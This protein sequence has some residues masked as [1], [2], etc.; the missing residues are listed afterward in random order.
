MLSLRRVHPDCQI[1]TLAFD[2]SD[3]AYLVGSDGMRL[4]DPDHHCRVMSWLKVPDDWTFLL[5]RT[6]ENSH[7]NSLVPKLQELGWKYECNQETV[8]W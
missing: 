8:Q 1:P 2:P 3:F 7:W 6:V 4:F 5:R